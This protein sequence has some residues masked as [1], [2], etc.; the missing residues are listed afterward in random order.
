MLNEKEKKTLES[1]L[2]ASEGAT[3]YLYQDSVGKVTIGVGNLIENEDAAAELYL[4]TENGLPASDKQKRE[5][6][7][8]VWNAPGVRYDGFARKAKTYQNYTD[9]RISSEEIDKLLS[10]KILQFYRGIKI[11]FPCFDSFPSPAKLA[12]MDM[13]FNLGLTG[14]NLRWP[15]LKN[16]VRKKIWS[17]AAIESN[18]PQLSILRNR[19]VRDLF[20]RAHELEKTQK[21]A[22]CAV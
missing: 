8:R 2:R 19:E 4:F 20:M 17:K 6:Y 12:L 22:P 5:A 11:I 18:R 16:A 9:I 15:K 3:N 21:G 7:Q 13:A 10:K 1:M 14:L